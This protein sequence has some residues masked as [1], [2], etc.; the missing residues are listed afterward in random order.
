M[1]ERHY[2]AVFLLSVI[3]PLLVSTIILIIF[4]MVVPNSESQMENPNIHLAG[5]ES[6]QQVAI[7]FS[8]QTRSHLLFIL[9]ITF[10]CS[11]FVLLVVFIVVVCRWVRRGKRYAV[12]SHDFAVTDHPVYSSQDCQ[13]KKHTGKVHENNH[14]KYFIHAKKGQVNSVTLAALPTP[15]VKTVAVTTQVTPQSIK[16]KKVSEKCPKFDSK[17]EVETCPTIQPPNYGT[18]GRTHLLSIADEDGYHIDNLGFESEEANEE[19]FISC[20]EKQRPLK[21]LR[22]DTFPGIVNKYDENTEAKG[23]D[24]QGASAVEK[25]SSDQIKD[26]EKQL[27]KQDSFQGLPPFESFDKYLTLVRLDSTTSLGSYSAEDGKKI[28]ESIEEED[29]KVKIKNT[30]RKE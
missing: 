16:E 2:T 19:D 27:S 23:E 3:V 28:W 10:A 26:H 9:G 12:G 18:L 29:E 20:F 14:A 25:E 5:N 30:S 13:L 4:V 15:P 22:E 21:T 8:S 24:I 7:S 1:A 11:V 17:C 6:K